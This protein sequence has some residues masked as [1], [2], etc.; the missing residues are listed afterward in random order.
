MD[1]GEGMDGVMPVDMNRNRHDADSEE[2][3]E[4]ESSDPPQ[5]AGRTHSAAAA[6]LVIATNPSIAA[7]ESAQKMG[8]LF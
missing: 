1:M 2:E 3:H 4:E 8:L 6:P 7:T 5:E